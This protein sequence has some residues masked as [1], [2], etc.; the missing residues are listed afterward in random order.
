MMVDQ[1]EKGYEFFE[2]TADMGIRASG[3]TL[4]EL[5]IRMAQGLTELLAE[6][7]R[8]EPRLTRSIHLEADA[9]DALLLAWL[10]ELLFRAEVEQ[11]FSRHITAIELEDET[12]QA[13]VVGYR[14]TPRPLVKGVALNR[15]A[16]EQEG[17]VWN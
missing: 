12:L 1:H 16:F 15:L 8:L 10:N 6:D 13:T 2:H 9:A 14:G 4:A 3:K 5:L 7:S 17:G 11:F